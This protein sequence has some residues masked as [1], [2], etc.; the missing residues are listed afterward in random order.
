M[1]SKHCWQFTFIFSFFFFI[2]YSQFFLQS[3]N[4]FRFIILFIRETHND[5]SETRYFSLVNM[6]HT[7]TQN[8]TKNMKFFSLTFFFCLPPCVHLIVVVIIFMCEHYYFFCRCYIHSPLNT[9]FAVFSTDFNLNFFFLAQSWTTTWTFSYAWFE[10]Y[11]YY[12]PSSIQTHTHTFNLVSFN[13]LLS[14]LCRLFLPWLFFFSKDT[15]FK[16]KKKKYYYEYSLCYKNSNYKKSILSAISFFMA[17]VQTN[18]HTKS[19]WEIK[20]I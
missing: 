10:H 17:T 11:F 1:S 4:F 20:N 7:H 18:T 13:F 3:F 2:A 9:I 5:I 15:R 12:F 8:K 6:K 16:K 19:V 14:I